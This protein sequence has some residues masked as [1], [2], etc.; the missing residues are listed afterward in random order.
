M[1]GLRFRSFLLDPM[2]TSASGAPALPAWAN[3]Y[4]AQLEGTETSTAA[5]RSNLD[6]LGLHVSVVQ[7]QQQARP[8]P[9][10]STSE[11]IAALASTM[12]AAGEARRRAYEQ[13]RRAALA[14]EEANLRKANDP[15]RL[16]ALSVDKLPSVEWSGSQAQTECAVC[17]QR[18]ADGEGLV[19]L[20]C[21]PL[22]I[23][24]RDCVARWLERQASCPLCRQL[25]V[26]Q[27]AAEEA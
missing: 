21:S 9:T 20:P 5:V 8:R 26:S 1:S 3:W 25:V 14:L 6:S 11:T 18:F 27:E 13:Q 17:T 7:P 2:T 15:A 19:H 24:H 4:V 22:H 10:V 12:V 16:Q 23:F